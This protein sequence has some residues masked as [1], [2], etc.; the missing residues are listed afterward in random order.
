[1]SMAVE[2]RP[3]RTSLPPHVIAAGAAAVRVAPEV[4]ED[5]VRLALLGGPDVEVPGWQED[6]FCH[7]LPPEAFYPGRG[8][9]RK[10]VV[11]GCG[12][13]DVQSACLAAALSTGEKDGIWGGTT[14]R[15][16]IRLRKVLREAGVMG[17][18]GEDAYL[19]WLSEGA[20]REPP[21]PP[22]TAAVAVTPR[23]HQ[24]DA[25]DAVCGAI[26]A[27]GS[28]Q[29]AMAT[30]S[31]KTHVGLWAAERLGARRVL[32]LVPNL[33]LVSQTAQLWS[34]SAVEDLE[35]LA[36]CSDTG[37]LD[38]EATTD[39]SRVREFFESAGDAMAVVFATY[40]S[41]AVLVASGVTFDLAVADEAHHLAGEAD[42]PFAAIVRG[43]IPTERTLYMTAT[44]RRFRRHGGDVD[45]VG[46][47]VDGAFGP[48]VYELMLSDAVDSGI[49]AD[50]RVV[51]AAVDRA[52]FDRVA[53]HPDLGD[54][55]PHLLAGAIAVVRAMGDSDL[56]SC[57][58]FHT[59][60][61]RAR[62][63]ASLIGVVAEALPGFEPPGP[64]WAGFLHG[65]ASVRIR[66]RLLARLVNDAT[67]GVVANA[68]TLGEGVDVPT[69]D[70]IAIVDPK[71]SE[72][73]VMQAVGRALRRPGRAAKVGTVLLPVL[74]AS[75]S[76]DL[77]DPLAGVDPR[78]LEVVA[79]V[80]RA[81]RGHDTALSS[82]LDRTRR[83]VGKTSRGFTDAG[84]G[85]LMR[86]RAARG[87]LRSR[88][89]LW[90]PGGATGE[91]AG[92]ISLEVLRESTA[93][94]EEAFG[95]VEAWLAEHGSMPAQGVEVPD[96]T[97]TFSLGAWCTVQ[98]SL[99][100][101]G[102]L[103][104]ERVARLDRLAGWSWDPR[105]EQWWAKFAALK[106]YV[107]RYGRIPARTVGENIR[108][109]NVGSFVN[110]TR[111]AFIHDGKDR[112]WLLQF[113]DRIAALEALPGWVWNQR[114]ADWEQHF[115][116]LGRWVEFVGH[117]R[118]PIGSLVDGFDVGRWVGKQRAAVNGRR[119]RGALT[120]ERIARLR[121]L[122]GW[123]DDPTW[124]EGMREDAWEHGFARL[125]A[126]A[127]THGAPAS[128]A[129]RC[130][131]GFGLGKWI[132]R[133][134]DLYTGRRSKG[135][136][137]PERIARI[138]SIPGWE[139]APMA[140]AVESA[141][142]VLERYAE[143]F[144]ATNPGRLLSV[145]I[146]RIDDYDLAA[147]VVNQRRR[148]AERRMDAETVERFE[149]VPGWA[150]DLSAAKFERGVR[151]VATFAEC[152]GHLRPAV[153]VVED[154]V[155]LAGWITG[156][157]SAYARRSLSPERIAA[158]EAIP[159]WAWRSPTLDTWCDQLERLHR[160]VRETGDGSPPQAL[161]F[162]GVR[163]GSWVAKQRA[164]RASL[165]AARAELLEAIPG[166]RWSVPP[167]PRRGDLLVASA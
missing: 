114:D 54:V 137:A 92:A 125:K 143:R 101:R 93:G 68:K 139:W 157:R 20:D 64:G 130:P 91:L 6:A 153:D 44:P 9:F 136:L 128:Q 69:L 86:K 164:R 10:E 144:A 42:K 58:S 98:R 95:R 27:G 109:V 40:H 46:M 87:L 48:R 152:E 72:Q 88:V 165:P 122:P 34:T 37:E 75:G 50:Y 16:R 162:E 94:W 25:V 32:V 96:A 108:G 3:D 156:Q 11:E 141:M 59:R 142:G 99:R 126:Y 65:G 30:A 15:A 14:G 160:Y 74:L 121:G 159:E 2:A 71:T 151:A 120:D 150:W 123:V 118:P 103:A 49:V 117:A 145:P 21:P 146:E 115:A 19:A 90:V 60:V 39:P 7:G 106:E 132:T 97:G 4:L 13:C 66:H 82:R 110:V 38:L 43:E 35:Q 47:D 31:G 12:R 167:G 83:A 18:V 55:D 56:R 129:Y 138:E 57:L 100:R 76:H 52:T 28:C 161:E 45:M 29:I 116:E 63:F 73:D 104:P 113:P 133:Q 53:S 67:W 135:R 26:A 89:E 36:V 124:A 77:E 111:Q 166:W 80:L 61:D 1:M 78:S 85:Q 81:L 84:I 5:A 23:P 107:E 24:L 8:E 62:T 79:G 134:R 155:N 148:Y 112:G 102:L 70:A 154:G 149:R 163:L 22:P 119:A 17:V 140:A 158:C 127:D 33:S 105:D 51:V 147:F 131:D 41:S